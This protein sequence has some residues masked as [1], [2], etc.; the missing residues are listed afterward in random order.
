M[1]AHRVTSLAAVSAVIAALLAFFVAPA[2]AAN[3]GDVWL[4]NSSV[5]GGSQ[6]HEPHLSN[7][8]IYLH[9]SDLVASSGTYD[10]ASIAGTGSGKTI[11]SGLAWS[12][13]GASDVIATIDGAALVADAISM[14]SAVANA[15]QGY[16]FK[17][18]VY[19]PAANASVATPASKSNDT[20]T[21]TFW[22]GGSNVAPTPSLTL[23]KAADAASAT[24]GGTIGFTITADTGSS[25]ADNVAISDP[26]PSG[27]GI[28]WS[29]DPAY[30]GPGT[31]SIAGSAPQTLSCTIGDLD[32]TSVSVHVKSAT[33]AGTTAAQGP[34]TVSNTACATFDDASGTHCSTAST[35]VDPAAPDLT[36]AKSADAA[37]AHVGT[38]VG[39]T[40]TVGNEGPGVA[41]GATISDPLQ[42]TGAGAWSI[43]PAYT[44]PGTCS[45]TGTAPTQAL[46]CALG[47]LAAG[48]TA[49]VHVAASTPSAS[50]IDIT[51]VASVTATN[52]EPEQATA[53]TGTTKAAMTI[54]KVADA[55]TTTAGSNVGFTVSV[56]N[57]GPGAATGATLTDPLPAFDGASWSITPAYTGQGTCA[58][59]GASPNQ[60]LSCQFGD[61]GA[62]ATASVH[63]I[64]ATPS[65]VGLVLTNVASAQATNN[66]PVTATAVTD[67]LLPG[68]TLPATFDP[69][70]PPTHSQVQVLGESLSRPQQ[71]LGA[72]LPLT[73]GPSPLL[74]ALAALLLLAGTAVLLVARQRQSPATAPAG[75]SEVSRPAGQKPQGPGPGAAGKGGTPTKSIGSG[76]GRR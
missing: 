52:N 8:T 64:T 26:L 10:I 48:V 66:D 63:V 35:I 56:G 22:V 42:A 49:T 32:A 7:T 29:I 31:C 61:L 1:N 54:T 47:N 25:F 39:F 41:L 24:A 6:A 62:G 38:L 55:V 74:F 33:V 20:K 50:T 71:D 2:V 13:S 17:I 21:K 12:A 67:S 46:S 68:Q 3:D 69:G 58:V 76:K 4:T 28:N 36:I 5:A 72:V 16:H 65:T 37:L 43:S 30:A 34:L 18:T 57:A 15:N 75:R 11:W 27:D 14:D 60:T 70:T 53:H 59:T 19:Q 23:T 73:G 44:G 9:G 40:I 45:V 51:N